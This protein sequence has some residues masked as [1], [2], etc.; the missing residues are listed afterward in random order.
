MPLTKEQRDA[1]PS[2]HFA[3]PGKRRLPINDE[4]HTKLAWD[5]VDRTKGLTDAEKKDARA[6]IV[7]RARELGIDTSKWD[8]S[9]A[10][11][12]DM[13]LTL[14][15]MSLD[16]P[17]VD[18]HPNRMP[19]S[20]ILVRLDTPSDAAVGGSGGKRTLLPKAVAAAA[21]PS[22]LGMPIDFTPNF[23]GH[24]ARQKIGTITAATIDGDAIKIEGFFYA[25]DFPTEC[26]LIQAEQ[27]DLG[28]SYEIRAQT[29]LD[30]D[31]LKII[32]G[33]FTGAAV[34]YKSKAAYQ[35]TSLAAEAEEEIDTMTKEE[36][37]ALLAEAVG[38]INTKLTALGTEVEKIKTAKPAADALQANKEMM[39]RVSSHTTALKNCAA[40]MEAAGIGMH[41]ERGHVRILR[42][43]AA[44]MEADA[45]QGRLPHIYRDHDWS[46]GHSAVDVTKA[47]AD[48][49]EAA[50]VKPANKDDAQAKALQTAIET[51]M[52]PLADK[53]EAANTVIND[54]KAK[55]FT[56]TKP[57]ER[58]TLSAEGQLLLNKTQLKPDATTGK[59]G[60]RA[61]DAAIGSAKLGN[62]E[63]L[64]LKIALQSANM[65]DNAA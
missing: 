54:L 4:R 14:A 55:G 13:T 34:L 50:G 43:M 42:H 41:S 53:L 9:M 6:K 61:L 38:P 56:E 22:L 36:L 25:A 52:K 49:L 40:S 62:S 5:M 39:D 15:A 18:D 10:H 26:D 47:V 3:V 24:N 20:G 45:A 33:S 44:G 7:T 11:S 63:S 48:A 23:N 16:L 1:L 31:I 64:A 32:G 19:F 58:K 17:H 59:I 51:A 2:G 21:L 65:L 12:V 35:S 27:A 30:G 57:P 46:F 8:K 37:Q 28:F 29:E 60:V